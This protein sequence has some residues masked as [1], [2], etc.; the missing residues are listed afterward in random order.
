MWTWSV[1]TSL[2]SRVS[3]VAGMPSLSSRMTSSLRPAICQP[4]SSQKSSQPLYMSLPAWA[5]APEMGEMNPILTGPCARA[6]VTA[7]A[8]VISAP[9][10]TTH[11]RRIDVPPRGRQYT[12]AVRPFTVVILAAALVVT[13][14]TAHAQG[15][16][17]VKTLLRDLKNPDYD[18]AYSAI[19][20]L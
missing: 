1:S 8:T 14:A 9:R 18:A 20:A 16:A 17:D 12:R 4:L 11:R 3:A 2:R 15:P 19:N 6:S 10:T 5:M 7:M 13:A